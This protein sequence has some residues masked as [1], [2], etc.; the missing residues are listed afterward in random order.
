MSANTQQGGSSKVIDPI[1]DIETCKRDVK[2]FKELG[3]NTIRVYTIDNT[4]NHDECMKLLADAG[5]YLVLDVNTPKYSIN[6]AGMLP[7]IPDN[8]RMQNFSC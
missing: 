4:K 6:R 8:S 7:D 5:I 3:L 2:Y 1:A